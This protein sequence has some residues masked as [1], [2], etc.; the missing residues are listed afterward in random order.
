MSING[1]DFDDTGVCT[2][3]DKDFL[4]VEGKECNA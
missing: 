3:C 1:H 2:K 4:D